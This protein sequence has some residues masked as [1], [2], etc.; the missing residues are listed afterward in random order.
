VLTF[1]PSFLAWC[2]ESVS[3]PQAWR[4]I[5]SDPIKRATRSGCRGWD[6]R[7]DAEARII[8]SIARLA[9]WTLRKNSVSCRSLE[10]TSHW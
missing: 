7:H 4:L 5:A 2:L 10:P 8:R 9:L 1:K 6:S 3:Q